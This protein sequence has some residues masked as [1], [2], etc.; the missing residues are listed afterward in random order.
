M[1]DCNHHVSQPFPS[2]MRK[3]PKDV[4][5]PGDNPLL[6]PRIHRWL[7]WVLC[8]ISI[9]KHWNSAFLQQSSIFIWKVINNEMIKLNWWLISMSSYQLKGKTLRLPVRFLHPGW[10]CRCHLPSWRAKAISTS[11]FTRWASLPIWFTAGGWEP[12]LSVLP[13]CF[14]QLWKQLRE[15]RAFTFNAEECQGQDGN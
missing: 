11:F 15:G 6:F 3:Q 13:G 8:Y 12:V 7:S 2:P 4:N 1:L 9:H 10:V 5:L 14:C